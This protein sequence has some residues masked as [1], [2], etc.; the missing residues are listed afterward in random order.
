MPANPLT[1]KVFSFLRELHKN[2]NREWF[3]AHK[4]QYQEAHQQ[5]KQFFKLLQD[6]LSHYDELEGGKMHRIYRDIRFSNDK[7]PYKS[8]F[9]GG[10]TRATKWKRG[11][12]YLQ[13]RPGGSFAGGGFW[14]P[15]SKDIKRIREELAADAQ[16][17]RD[18]LTTKDFKETFGE[19]QGEQVKTAPRGYATDHPNIDLLRYKQFLLMHE[20]SDQEVMAPDFVQQVATVYSKML[21][22][23]N[24]MSEVLTTDANGM[25]LEDL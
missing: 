3:N 25:P 2:N 24:F 1:P 11:G 18:I 7:T 17:V 6:E 5:V 21:P 9:S 8:Q 19:L 12:Y 16:P 13:L 4:D 15:N 10:F 23:F 14:G 22:F 20:F